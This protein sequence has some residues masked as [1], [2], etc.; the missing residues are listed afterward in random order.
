MAVL[1]LD[2]GGTKLA[3]AVFSQD[4]NMR[5]KTMAHLRGRSGSEVGA[6]ISEQVH[7]AITQ[8]RHEEIE[9]IGISVPGIYHAR[10]GT[11]WAPNI[12]GWTDYPLVEELTTRTGGLLVRVDSDRACS[13]LGE[14]W[15]GSAQGC[16]NAVF[17]A[18]GTGIGAGILVD[19]TV[20]RGHSDI[21]GATGW[22]ALESCFRPEYAGCGCFEFHASGSGL[23]HRTREML[24]EDPA[25]SGTLRSIPADDLT[26]EHVFAAALEG[27]PLA[28]HVIARA[29]TYWGMATANYVSLFDPEMIIFGGGVFGPAARFLDRIRQEAAR[30]AQPINMRRV[31]LTCS[32]LGPDAA[33]YGAGRLALNAG[34][35]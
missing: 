20:L 27:D 4:G 9:A 5:G 19:G 25:Y 2:L 3:S 23:A 17:V 34:N 28:T 22:M 14:T 15:R 32:A 13:I 11:V 21:A 26:T 10:T 33:L 18:V 24:D 30:W 31:K 12:P 7:H 8:E 35:T 1:A 6:L 16:R 29:I